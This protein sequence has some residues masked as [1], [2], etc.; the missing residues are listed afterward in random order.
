LRVSSVPNTADFY[1]NRQGY[2]INGSRRRMSQGAPL[3]LNNSLIMRAARAATTAE[4][5]SDNIQAGATRFST[6]YI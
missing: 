4:A 2:T 3:S 6:P 5:R 1:A